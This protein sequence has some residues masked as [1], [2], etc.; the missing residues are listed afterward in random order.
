MATMTGIAQVQASSINNDK[1]FTLNLKVVEGGDS[2]RPPA[3]TVTNAKVWSSSL[4]HIGSRQLTD[5]IRTSD[6]TTTQ[7]DRVGASLRPSTVIVTVAV[8][9]APWLSRTV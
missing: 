2:G 1:R 7:L 5:D 9:L 8:E 3:L 6:S 4:S